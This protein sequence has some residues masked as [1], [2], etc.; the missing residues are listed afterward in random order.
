MVG[1]PK[2]QYVLIF[3]TAPQ[4]C[5]LGV[6]PDGIDQTEGLCSWELISSN[7]TETDMGMALVCL[8]VSLAFLL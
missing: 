7:V 3:L 5:A 6:S 4:L 1:T 2:S 8:D